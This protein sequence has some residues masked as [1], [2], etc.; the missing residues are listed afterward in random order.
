MNTALIKGAKK[1]PNFNVYSSQENERHFNR[2]GIYSIQL[3]VKEWENI[4]NNI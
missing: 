4:Y 3:E 1:H 2:G